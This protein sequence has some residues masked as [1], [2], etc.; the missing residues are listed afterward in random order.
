[1]GYLRS[2]IKRTIISLRFFTI[3]MGIALACIAG[4]GEQIQAA[5]KYPDFTLFSSL[6]QL[7]YILIFDRYKCV[8]VAFLA[9][10]AGW[11]MAQDRKTHYLREVLFRTS[12]AIYLRSKLVVVLLSCTLGAF[13]GFLICS[14]ALLPLIPF[15]VSP[16]ASITAT[17]FQGLAEGRKAIVF[18]LLLSVNFGLSAAVPT[19]IGMWIAVHYPSGYI[20][21]GG[22]VLVFYLLYSF[23]LFLPHSLCYSDLSSGFHVLSDAG[24]PETLLWHGAFW[25]I[26][27]FFAW[28][29]LC[30]SMRRK[31]K[32]GNLV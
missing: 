1:M 6:R 29:L 3:V 12:I 23:S 22:A 32:N 7:E 2:E 26:H 4:N 30:M 9:G 11:S 25:A 31:Y 10:S 28:K 13:L 18:L 8:F 15:S 21:V 27:I 24:I 5:L 20:A 17:S 19:L 14:L 16:E